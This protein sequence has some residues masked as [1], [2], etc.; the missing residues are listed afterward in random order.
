MIVIK[1]GGSLEGGAETALVHGIQEAKRQGM[2]VVLV[3]GGDRASRSGCGMR[4]L[5]SHL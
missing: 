2:P 5:S 4:A 1:L 3:H